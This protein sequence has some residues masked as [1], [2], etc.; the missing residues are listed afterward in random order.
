MEH[1][2][3]V[4]ETPAET[5]HGLRGERD[6]RHQHDGGASLGEHP[7]DGLQVHFRLARPG[8]P[9]HHHDAAVTGIAG[10]ADAFQGLRLPL[11]EPRLGAGDEVFPRTLRCGHP[12]QAATMLYHNDS[13]RFQG[14]ERR[15][16]VP[17][18]GGELAHAQ[19][20]HLQGC[21]DS[22]LFD[23]PLARLEALRV[24]TQPD[25]AVV[26]LAGCRLAHHPLPVLLA[27][28]R[29][30]ARR[31]E[32][33]HAAGKRRDI[34]LRQEAG[35]FGCGFIE[36]GLPQYR[37]DGLRLGAQR[38]VDFILALQGHD[39]AHGLPMAERH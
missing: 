4:A 3:H 31:R 2:H 15:G 17:I 28:R 5:S 9:V 20:T 25:P 13:A 23:G 7:L 19:R 33:A 11:R 30:A 24:G 35:A 16:D 38:F 36:E 27:N 21:Q 1:G 6:L 14:L 39:E 26:Y 10:A 22:F 12:A 37:L 32:Q 18:F 8:Y 29:S 34:A